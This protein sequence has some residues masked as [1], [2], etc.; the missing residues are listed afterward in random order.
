MHPAEHLLRGEPA[1]LAA[2]RAEDRQGRVPRV[3]LQLRGEQ[4]LATGQAQWGGQFIPNVKTF[5]LRRARTTTFWFPPIA[6]V[7]LFP[8]PDGG[9]AE[10]CCGPAGDGLR[11][12][13]AARSRRSASTAT[14]RP[15]NQTGIVTPTFC[16]LVRHSAARQYNY[17]YNPS[18]AEADPGPGRLHEGAN[19]IF[20]HE[21]QAAAFTVINVGGYS[22]WVA[23]MQMI[24]QRA[25]GRRYQDHGRQPVADHDFLT[26]L[27][28]GNYQLAYNF[29]SGGP[30]PYYEFRQCAVQKNSAPIG[31]TA[32][33][34]TGSATATRRPTS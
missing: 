32:P 18:K 25:E 31:K 20:A 24:Q 21:R 26:G 3:H 11:H 22:D 15:A 7:S 4:Y 14:S 2:W 10:R 9:G 16:R 19:G 30:T 33:R 34:P 12:R 29:Q 17:S 8:Q 13:P 6:N 27:Y 23:S 5:Y 28:K 1:L